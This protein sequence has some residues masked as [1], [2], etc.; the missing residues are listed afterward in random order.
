MNKM[1]DY[2]KENIT[3][4]TVRKVNAILKSDDFTIEKVRNA[5]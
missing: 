3:E 5:S 2:D 1:I 4:G